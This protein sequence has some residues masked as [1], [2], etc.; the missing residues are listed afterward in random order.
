M[1]NRV[2]ALAIHALQQ[3]SILAECR[4][5]VSVVR[6]ELDLQTPVQFCCRNQVLNFGC[7]WRE[8]PRIQR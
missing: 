6:L 2:N 8:Q 4:L 1:R 7:R 3:H 5:L